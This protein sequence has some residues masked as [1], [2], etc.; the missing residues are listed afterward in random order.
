VK[1]PRERTAAQRK[2]GYA[3]PGV[4]L[5]GQQGKVASGAAAGNVVKL[6]LTTPLAAPTVSYLDSASWSPD[7]LLRGQNGIA[8]LTFREASIL[9]RR[10]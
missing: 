1:A 7:R 4:G 2:E 3:A 10:P 5:D 8:A 6:K 9:R